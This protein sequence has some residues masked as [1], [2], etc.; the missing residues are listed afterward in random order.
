M[1]TGAGAG[2]VV[3][4]VAAMGPAFDSPEAAGEP[5]RSSDQTELMISPLWTRA[6]AQRTTRATGPAALR[7]SV[8][9]ALVFAM[10]IEATAADVRVRVF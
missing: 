7:F 10:T 6:R 3:A 1:V 5:G 2:M 8:R 4:D 9:M